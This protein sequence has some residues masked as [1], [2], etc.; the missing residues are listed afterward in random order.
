MTG[1]ECSWEYGNCGVI[2]GIS[3]AGRWSQGEGCD[4]RI[5][6]DSHW[7]SDKYILGIVGMGMWR[8]DGGSEGRTGR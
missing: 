6:K 7:V 4:P 2:S 3:E 8:E 5:D 1:I